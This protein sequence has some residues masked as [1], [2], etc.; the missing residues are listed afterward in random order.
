[1]LCDYAEIHSLYLRMRNPLLLT[2]VSFLVLYACRQTERERIDIMGISVVMVDTAPLR[3][4]QLTDS[5]LGKIKRQDRLRVLMNRQRAFSNSG[6]P[7]SAL[8][9]GV[10]IRE[11]AG[12]YGD[13]LSMAKSLLYI[14][15]SISAEQQRLFEPYLE[16][17]LR[18]FRREKIVYEQGVILGLM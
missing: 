5:L 2:L 17:S 8:S 6:M 15:G 9:T 4:I 12:E 7:D 11:L 18:A 3:Y 14:K 16:I 13:S 10:Q 1:M